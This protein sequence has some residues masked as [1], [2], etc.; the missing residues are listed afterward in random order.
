[1]GYYLVTRFSLLYKYNLILTSLLF[2][3]FLVFNSDYSFSSLLLAVLGAISSAVILYIILYLILFLFSFVGRFGLYLTAFCFLFV[4]VALIIDFF[5]YRLYNFHINAM[6]INILTSPKALD[7]IQLGFLSFTGLGIFIFSLLLLQLFW[8]KSLL[9]KDIEELKV[10]NKKWNK[11]III[12]LFLVVITEKVTYGFASLFS[13]T[14]ILNTFRVIP[15]YQ[16]LT[17]N[18]L[19]S[20]YFGIQMQK[21]AENFIPSATILDYPKQALVSKKPLNKPNI[22]IIASDAVNDAILHDV[23]PPNIEAFKKD[24]LV[25]TNHYSGG[26]STRFGIF[27]LFYGLNST[28][29]FP[30]LSSQKGPVFFGYLKNNGYEINIVSSTNTDWPEFNKTAYINISDN[31]FDTFEGSPW[32]KDKKSSQKALDIIENMDT[33]KPQFTF[34]FMDAPHGYSFPET[35]HQYK[36]SNTNINYL[37]LKKDSPELKDIINSYKNSLI[38]NDMLFGKII[39]KL[40]KKGV[41]DNSIIIYTSD[42]GHELF[43]YGFFGHNSAFSESQTKVPFI[44]KIPEMEPEVINKMTSHLDFVPTIL[45]YIGVQ[46]K[47]NDYSNGYNMLD[48]NFKRNSVFIANWNNN[49]IK[50]DEYTHVFSNLPNKMF[51]N[52]IRKNSDYTHADGQ[53]KIDGALIM[54]TMKENSHFYK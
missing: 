31:V 37:T 16:P 21:Q 48:K 30:F 19:A 7:S 25:F 44:M 9:N 50:T 13:N 40:K 38:Y 41:Y 22:F 29:W 4:H 45:S 1:M 17:F 18:R 27:S 14:D 12:P 26:N 51:K 53:H 5:I 2:L 42:H 15:L 23:S 39:A 8:L 32:E 54:S 43:Q 49:A 28:Y 10:K 47:P 35:H 24:S 46:N 34:L 11:A 3:T 20:K 52:E 6:V 33:K 36:V